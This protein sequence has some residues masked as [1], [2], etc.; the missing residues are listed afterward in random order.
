MSCGV[1]ILFVFQP[2]LLLAL[3][4]LLVSGLFD[5][6]QLAANA[7]FVSAVPARQRSQAFGIAQGQAGARCPGGGATNRPNATAPAEAPHA[8]A[9]RIRPT[10]TSPPPRSW[11]SGAAMPSG[12]L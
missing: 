2:P 5:C 3:L 8:P 6:Y 4:V 9:A 12:A 7:E 1:L 11:A 10:A